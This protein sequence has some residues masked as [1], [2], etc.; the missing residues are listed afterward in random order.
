MPAVMTFDTLVEDI[1]AYSE[2]SLE[3]TYVAQIPR[4]IALAEF[5]LA[6]EWRGLGS[7]LWVTGAFTPNQPIVDKPAEWRETISWNYGTGV[8]NQD[9]NYLLE[10]SLEY[11]RV[12]WPNPTAAL[13]TR[14]PKYYA[15]Y[16]WDHFFV[17]PTPLVAYPFE[18]GYYTKIVPL[19][20]AHQTNWLTE[21]APQLLL[22]ACMLQAQPFLKWFGE[23]LEA[24]KGLYA[25][26]A[27]SLSLEARNQTIDRSTV[28][29]KQ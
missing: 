7:Q 27:Q 29:D 10:R 20:A 26:Q 21:H 3:V 23:R 25:M 8:A 13:L 28:V 19:D 16:D 14:P 15:N 17:V 4:F 12:Y 18:L 6:A 1:G 22:A 9:R 24:W 5:Q 2:R 11:C